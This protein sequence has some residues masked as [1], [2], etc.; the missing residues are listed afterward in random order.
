MPRS[1]PAA[2][3]PSDF[4]VIS[5][6]AKWMKAAIGA[7]EDHPAVKRV[8]VQRFVQRSIKYIDEVCNTEPEN[9]QKLES[10]T[11]MS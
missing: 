11:M 2:D 8:T 4:D 6:D 1:N 5:F 10:R 9:I 7:L 3:Y